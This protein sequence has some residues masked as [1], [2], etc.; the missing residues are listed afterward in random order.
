MPDKINR[1][2][3]TFVL[4]GEGADKKS[5]EARARDKG[6]TNVRFVSQQPRETIPRYLAASDL[7]VVL[8]RN[9]PFFK[10][11]I[12]SK[13]FEI[14]G[15]A[16]PLILGVDGEART[17]L[18][19]AQAGVFI[20]PEDPHQLAQA[21]AEL[22]SNP[23]KRETMGQSGRLFVEENFSRSV[24]ARKYLDVLERVKSAG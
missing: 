18:H 19:Q 6:L 21:I 8:L 14:M 22:A 17:I 13:I 23:T 5:L 7:S 12:P 10:S 4:V 1:S 24:L 20:S 15:C 9:L 2:A 16:R 11:V 3:R